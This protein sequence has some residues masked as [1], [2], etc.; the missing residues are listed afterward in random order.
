MPLIT[1]DFSEVTGAVPPGTYGARITDCEQKT[2]QAG[3]TYLNWKLTLFGNPAVNDRVVFLST[4]ISGKGAFRLQEL[5]KAATG[6]D[7][8]KGQ[9]LDTDMLLTR[10]VTATLVEGRDQNGEPRKFPDVKS[11]S[12]YQA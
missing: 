1:P 5:Y 12:A 6:E 3:S 8:A 7:M 2:S 4:P 11:V 9:P 10:Q